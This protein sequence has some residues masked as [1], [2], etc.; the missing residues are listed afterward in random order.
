MKFFE[1]VLCQF[2]AFVVYAMLGTY[3]FAYCLESAF[4]K[5]IPW[6]ADLVAGVVGGT[7]FIPLAI[8]SWVC[9]LCDIAAPFFV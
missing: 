9:R 7:V 5:N 1:L 2:V 6:Y 8:I 4:A 3:C